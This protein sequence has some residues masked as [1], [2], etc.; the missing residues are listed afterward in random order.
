M[1]Q[2]KNEMNNNLFSKH[3]SFVNYLKDLVNDV[4]HMDVNALY[5]EVKNKEES[6][7]NDSGYGE[8]KEIQFGDFYEK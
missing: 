5:Q 1:R 3:H 8:E 6:S 7:D 2:E 4:E